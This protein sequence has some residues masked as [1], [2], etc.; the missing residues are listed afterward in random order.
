MVVDFPAPDGPLTAI[1]KQR[2]G[3]AGMATSACDERQKAF[4]RT[5]RKCYT[6]NY[7][8]QSAI[9]NLQSAIN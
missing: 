8:A 2:L 7:T 9:C 3:F 4:A 6:P 5:L 1:T